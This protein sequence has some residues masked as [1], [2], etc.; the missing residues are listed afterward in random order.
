M[1]TE[2]K[3]RAL[4]QLLEHCKA[5]PFYRERL[6]GRPLRSLEELKDIPLT[7]K[8]DLRS[9]SPLG[10][11][12]VPPR[13][14]FQ[15]HETFGTTGVP[16]S[17][18]FTREDLRYNAREI[19]LCGVD[20]NHDDTVLVRFPYS[21]S[22]IAHM[23][24]AAAQMKRACV[25]PVGAR[26]AVSPFPRV[27]TLLQKLQVT[28]LTCLPLQAV[29]IAETAELLGK[30]P[31]QDFPDLRAICTA[32]EPLSAGRRRLLQDIWGVPVFDIYGMAE[33]GTAVVDCEFGRPHPLEDYFV[34]EL[35]DEELKNEVKPGELGY[36]V[37]TALKKKAT[38]M[39]RYLT[40]DR[41]RFVEKECPC[42]ASASLEIRG[43]REDTITVGDRSLDLW[44][45]DEIVSHLPC[46]RFWAVG[47]APG[48]LH[49]VVEEERKSGS[50]SPQLINKLEKKYSMKLYIDV[51]P[52]GTLYD[53]SELLSVGVVGKPQYIYSAAEMGQKKYIKS[54]RM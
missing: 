6:P 9:L 26:S 22:A 15:Y 30:K 39:V 32:G 51:V 11:I 23:I 47:P 43:R 41:A 42:G 54:A 28:V 48:G 13:E 16:V 21:I 5:S 20:F 44:D 52:R 31:N 38:P 35:L 45:L 1:K 19:T 27:I 7:T 37:V 34:F 4:N 10:L 17:T 8:E 49:L 46:R 29:L 36:L 3:L 12:C 2:E 53:R 18:W 40:G 14:I 33:I 50:I 25:V 24:H